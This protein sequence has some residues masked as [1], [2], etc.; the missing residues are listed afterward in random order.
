MYCLVVFAWVLAQEGAVSQFPKLLIE[1]PAEFASIR[2]RL[3]SMEPERFADIARLLGVTEEGPPIQVILANEN[4][5]FARS[6]SSWIAGFAVGES[7]LVVIFPARSPSYPSRTLDDVVRHEIAHVLIR[8][9]AGGEPVPRWFNEG[10][11]M[12]VERERRFADQTQLLYQLMSGS[13][14]SL[15][16]IDRLF[17][18]GQNDQTRG[19]ALAGAF[20]HDLL[21]RYGSDSGAEILMRVR[22]GAAFNDAVRETT[23]ATLG[24]M[25][26]EFWKRQ[27]IWTTWLP[28]IGSST[29]LWLAVTF[30]ALLAIYRR[31]RRNREIEERW[32]KEDDAGPTPP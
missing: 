8:R 19:Y 28:I 4:S 27:R 6:V 3:E 15:D 32:E 24:A 1:G 2:K 13:R 25:E 29:T 9:A 11:S 17:S 26:A 7:N 21:E 10:L 30:L 14:T 5:N 31:R 16:Q 22:R 18:G 12:V 20:V 23:G